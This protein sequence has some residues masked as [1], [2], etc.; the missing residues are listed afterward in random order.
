MK[1]RLMCILCLITAA[2]LFSENKNK[3]FSYIALEPAANRGFF[4]EKKADGLGGW[5]DFGPMS[6]LRSIPFGVQHFTDTP[7]PFRVIDPDKNNGKSV[8]VLSG[9]N[10]EDL[11][12]EQSD[13]IRVDG[14]FSELYFLHTTMFAGFDDTQLPLIRYRIHY[15]DKTE[16][17]FDCMK[18]KHVDD[19]WGPPGRMPSAMRTY[20]E[21]HKYLITTPWK[22]PNPEKE[23]AWIRMESTGNAIPIL[24]AITGSNDSN[25]YQLFMDVINERIRQFNLGNLKIALIQRQ[26]EPDQQ[27][28]LEKGVI[29]CRKAKTLG[30][31]I[32]LFPEMYNIGYHDIDFN[33]TDAVEKWKSMAVSRDSRFVSRFQNLAEELE[34]AII[35]T[36]LESWDGLPRNAATLFDRHGK[37]VLT[38]A[39][40]HTCDFIPMEAAT[41]PG[42]GFHVS[43]LNT[44]LGS[45][46]VGVMIC[47]DREAPESARMLMLDGAELILTPNACPLN[48][49]QLKQFQVR[50]YEN[51]VATVMTNY[52][53]SGPETGFNGRSC[54]FH[55]DGGK[56]LIAGEQE[57]VIIGEVNLDRIREIRTNTVWG[58]A[59]RR[60]HKYRKLISDEV[61]DVFKR[62]DAFGK[63]FER[64]MR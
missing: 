37:E 9:P 33:E 36:Y 58:N 45:V 17:V 31:D 16:S 44:R 63:P 4:D 48:E 5:T 13:P 41:T 55:A 60:P 50:A 8:V 57:D 23:I 1:K 49:L 54:M 34:M 21:F 38:Y 20:S 47:Y 62:E 28:N 15:T 30:A 11:F 51:A 64:G 29:M 6:S 43:T 10:R 14:K 26:S 40:V 2:S 53:S 22:N 32:A 25:V 27:V 35:I 59:F 42:D 12:P 39:K 7:V 24:V 56:I 52:A 46:K 18:G 19:W 3:P 61:E